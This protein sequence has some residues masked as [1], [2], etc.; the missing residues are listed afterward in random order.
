MSIEDWDNIE[1][2]Y[3][4]VDANG[5]VQ[6]STV[7]EDCKQ[8]MTDPTQKSCTLLLGGLTDHKTKHGIEQQYN[9]VAGIMMKPNTTGITS[10]SSTYEWV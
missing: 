3:E 7:W 2:L 6:G 5:K 1:V 9:P 10:Y 4:N 8:S